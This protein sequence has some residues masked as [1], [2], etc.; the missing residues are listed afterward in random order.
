MRADEFISRVNTEAQAF[1]QSLTPVKAKQL[2][3]DARAGY[4]LYIG[5]DVIAVDRDQDRSLQYYGGFE[6]VD[7]NYRT[8]VGDFVFY[9]SGDERVYDC[10]DYYNNPDDEEGADE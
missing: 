9:S 4:Q 5:D 7:K 10:L 8:E 6:Y 1:V 3:L 2:G